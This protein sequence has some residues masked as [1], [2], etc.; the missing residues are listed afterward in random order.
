MSVMDDTLTALLNRHSLGIKYLAEPAPDDAQLARMVEAAL[1]AP[2]HASLVPFRL[3]AVR[4]AARERLAALFRQAAIDAGKDAEA[5]ALDD[6]RA[7]EAP[8]VVA[9]IARIDLGHPQ[10][11][12][13]EQWMA[14]GGALT[15]F[16]NAA[17]LMGFAGKML[18]GRK[19][20][21]PRVV[22]AFCEPGETLVG[23]IGMGTATRPPAA[24]P[25]KARGI[26]VL[27]DW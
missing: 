16:L 8:L 17:H 13:H 1:R 23:W 21:D 18:S 4:G 27:R 12:A 15:N 14:V 6:Q 5:V 9:V 25:P 2:D 10:V 19:A 26:D 20:R 24:R 7:R 22:A 11:P 3:A